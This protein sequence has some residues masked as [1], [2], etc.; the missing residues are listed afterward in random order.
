MPAVTVDDIT[1]LPHIPQPDPA[2]T[3]MR[4]VI[5][6]VTAPRGFEGEGFPVHRAFAGTDPALIDPFIAHIIFSSDALIRDH[7]ATLRRTRNESLPEG[8]RSRLYA[9]CLIVVKLAG[10]WFVRTRHSSSRKTMSMT[11][12]RLFSM[13]Q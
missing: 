12:C 6:V 13:A 2:A 3:T 4:P 8:L 9:M 1:A 11:Q 10:A 7:P 5:S